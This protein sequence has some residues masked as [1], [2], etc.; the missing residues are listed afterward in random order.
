MGLK[1][2]RRTFIWHNYWL[3]DENEMVMLG[4]FIWAHAANHVLHNWLSQRSLILS[5]VFQKL[6]LHSFPREDTVFPLLGSGSSITAKSMLWLLSICFFFTLVFVHKQMIYIIILY[7]QM[8]LSFPVFHFTN[9]PNIRLPSLTHPFSPGNFQN[10][11]N[12]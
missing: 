12:S 5:F 9:L 8:V 7:I 6:V 10:F 3:L 11:Q 2:F 1:K 4:M